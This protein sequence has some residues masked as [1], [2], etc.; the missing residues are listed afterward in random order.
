MAEL[1]EANWQNTTSKEAPTVTSARFLS[2]A[3]LKSVGQAKRGVWLQAQIGNTQPV[4]VGAEGVTVDNGIQLAAGAVLFLPV[5]P[6]KVW[7]LAPAAAQ[8]LRMVV[9]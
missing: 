4:V 7:F 1:S 9:I 8:M 6:D 5:R 2:S 3:E